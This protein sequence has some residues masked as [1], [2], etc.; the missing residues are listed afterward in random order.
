MEKMAGL[1]WK[2]LGYA[3]RLN[4]HIVNFA[5]DFVICCRG[6]APQAM[7]AM[8][9]MME[10]LKLTVNEEKTKLCS[11]PETA[12]DFLGYSFQRC[13]KPRTGRAEAQ[14]GSSSF[15]SPSGAR[16]W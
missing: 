2:A 7:T 6:T 10:Q 4:A 11:V 1:G 9:Q 15:P 8:R 5:D 14:T 16:P 3:A 12:F 13:Y